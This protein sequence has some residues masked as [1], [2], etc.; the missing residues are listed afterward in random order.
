M[1]E[2]YSPGDCKMRSK[3]AL[4]Y[5]RGV[6]KDRGVQTF[7]AAICKLVGCVLCFSSVIICFGCYLLHSVKQHGKPIS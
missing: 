2:H 3:I 6:N 5:K 4:L 7:F 1:W